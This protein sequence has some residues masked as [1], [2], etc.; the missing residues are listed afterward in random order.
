[1][2]ARFSPVTCPKIDGRGF[3]VPISQDNN[4]NINTIAGHVDV[5]GNIIDRLAEYEKLCLEPDEVFRILKL[6]GKL[7]RAALDEAARRELL[8]ERWE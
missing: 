2:A 5:S 4:I 3:Y 6:Y 7:P 8:A 1:M